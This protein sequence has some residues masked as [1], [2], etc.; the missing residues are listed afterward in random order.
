RL[1]RRPQKDPAPYDRGYEH[2]RNDYEWKRFLHGLFDRVIERFVENAVDGNLDA[3]CSRGPIARQR[4]VAV[5]FLLERLGRVVDRL[6][7]FIA[8]T[9]NIDSLPNETNL[10]AFLRLI[11]FDDAMDGAIARRIRSSLVA[12]L[13]VVVLRHV[14]LVHVN[15]GVGRAGWL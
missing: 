4:R 2:N 12:G 15:I 8:R 10:R 1:P 11:Q 14:D 13:A 7:V 6:D 5:H 3:V 9:G